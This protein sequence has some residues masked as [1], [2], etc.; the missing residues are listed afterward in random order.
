MHN[1]IEGCGQ[2]KQMAIDSVK[3]GNLKLN[4]AFISYQIEYM[5]NKPSNF[6]TFLFDRIPLYAGVL[7]TITDTFIFLFLEKYGQ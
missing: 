4:F 6:D 7:I 3:R 5:G 2:C 1:K